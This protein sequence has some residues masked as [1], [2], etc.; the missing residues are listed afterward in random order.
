MATKDDVSEKYLELQMLEQQ[1][2]QV[3]QQIVNINAQVL[4]LQRIEGNLDDIAKTKGDTEILVS[5]G[6]GVLGKAELKDNQTVLMNVG[7][8]VVVEKDIPS[9]IE[10]I[11]HQIVQMKDVAMQ[12]EQEF[13]IL[14]MNSQVLQRDL[15]EMVSEIKEKNNNN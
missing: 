1:L 9:S 8:N 14:A 4:E 12:M 10:M 2:K 6:G 7:A 13:Q 11:K 15:Q 5:L 3:N